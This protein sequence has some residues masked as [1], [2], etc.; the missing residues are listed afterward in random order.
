MKWAGRISDPLYATH[1]LVLEIFI[2][3]YS[4]PD[5]APAWV[6]TTS[7]LLAVM[8]A[9]ATARW[10]EPSATAWWDRVVVPRTSGPL[11]A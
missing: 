10:F 3:R 7:V 6:V 5:T 9:D 11:T 8:L 1:F 2:V 4:G